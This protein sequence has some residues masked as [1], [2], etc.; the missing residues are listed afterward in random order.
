MICPPG[1]FHLGKTVRLTQPVTES[2]QV[3]LCFGVITL[4]IFTFGFAITA[5]T[6]EAEHEQLVAPFVAG[7]DMRCFSRKR[8]GRPV[9]LA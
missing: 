9:F 3:M 5:M 2:G 7:S 1:R 6:R 8:P 4:A